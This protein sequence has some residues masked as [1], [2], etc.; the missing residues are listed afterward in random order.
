MRPS[1]FAE[2]CRWDVSLNFMK[3]FHLVTGIKIQQSQE[4]MGHPREQF[5]HPC[6]LVQKSPFMRDGGSLL[7]R[8]GHGARS[9][10]LQNLGMF[11]QDYQF[12]S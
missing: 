9:L 4:L 2:F 8:L 1:H 6:T 11:L 5:Q 3:D 7:I 10:P 12:E